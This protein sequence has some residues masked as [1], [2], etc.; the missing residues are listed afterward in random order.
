MS[1]PDVCLEEGHDFGKTG[2][3]CVRCGFKLRCGGCGEVVAVEKLLGHI[4]QCRAYRDAPADEPAE[5]SS[6]VTVE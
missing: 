5:P 4:S 1:E 6:T 3:S 2:D